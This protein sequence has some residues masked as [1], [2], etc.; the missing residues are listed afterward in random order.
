MDGQTSS[1][2]PGMTASEP[3]NDSRAAPPGFI[4]KTLWKFSIRRRFVVNARRQLRSASLVALVGMIPVAMLNVILHLSRVFERES[5]FA[6]ISPDLAQQ[7]AAFDRNEAWLVL[8]ASVV[9]VVGVFVMT[10]LETHQTSGAAVGITRHLK[11]VRDGHYGCRLRLRS[12]DN[13]Q[14]L[15]EPFND[16]AAA[17]GDR[18]LLT[19]GRLEELAVQADG[20]PGAERLAGQLRQLSRDHV[21]LAGRAS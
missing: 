18:A 1:A 14:E 11:E 3:A 4:K 20:I 7:F 8:A 17:L 19:A 10:L 5:L 2:D 12:S 13:L 16:M 6:G 9:F 15:V 21:G